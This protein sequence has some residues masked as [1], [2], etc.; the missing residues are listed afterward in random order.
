MRILLI[1]LMMGKIADHSR[2]CGHGLI[3]KTH[4]QIYWF[5]LKVVIGV[6]KFV[7]APRCLSHLSPI[8]VLADVDDPLAVR[9]LVDKN[10]NTEA[11]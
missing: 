1:C 11:F 7:H 4:E 10:S 5:V 8:Q 3:K 2:P 6:V 9:T